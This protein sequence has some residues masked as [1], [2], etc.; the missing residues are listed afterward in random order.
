MNIFRKRH[1]PGLPHWCRFSLLT[2]LTLWGLGTCAA[3]A[4]GGTITATVYG[5]SG[6]SYVLFSVP[7][8]THVSFAVP[9]N[10]GFVD[11]CSASG[12]YPCGFSVFEQSWIPT[13]AATGTIGSVFCLSSSLCSDGRT[14]GPMVSANLSPGIYQ[15]IVF[16]SDSASI[17]SLTGTLTI[18]GDFQVL[19]EP[20]GG[21]LLSGGLT[22]LAGFA[23]MRRVP[24]T[25]AAGGA[26]IP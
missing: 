9:I 5:P 13:V 25:K 12:N 20:S 19:P 11:P 26:Q 7:Q 18:D 17:S 10:T 8:T 22:L 15:F 4:R 21:W 2:L 23:I 16:A 14:V 6:A 24:A 3:T 1:R